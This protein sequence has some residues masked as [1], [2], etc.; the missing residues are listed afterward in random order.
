MVPSFKK[1]ILKHHTLVASSFV[2]A[3]FLGLFSSILEDVYE[4]DPD[5]IAFDVKTAEWI[6]QIRDPFLNDLFLLITKLG[7]LKPL[8]FA[9]L[10]SIA[11]FYF[12]KKYKS[13]ATILLSVSGSAVITFV[14]KNIVQRARPE[15]SLISERGFS[16]P[17]AHAFIAVCFWGVLFYLIYKLIKNKLLKIALIIVAITTVLAIGFSRIYIG[18]HW[19][20][21][22][23]ASYLL[24][25]V[26]ATTVIYLVENHSYI[27]NLGRRILKR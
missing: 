14:I 9:F 27:V 23:I 11:F 24:S 16:F 5:V 4:S 15:L 12:Y 10:I 22:V 8:T 7:D 6:T 17:S 2:A 19:S 25:S 20:S 18:V 21:D 26:Y 3:V 1:W 13:L